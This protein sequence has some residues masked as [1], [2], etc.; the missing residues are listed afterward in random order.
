MGAAVSQDLVICKTRNEVL[1]QTKLA[2]PAK[3]SLA[4]MNAFQFPGKQDSGPEILL[5]NQLI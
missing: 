2:N 3:S 1:L 5:L 4:V